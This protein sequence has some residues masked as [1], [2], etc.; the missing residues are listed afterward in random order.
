[1]R[2]KER[3]TLNPN[4]ALN[5]RMRIEITSVL[6][7]GIGPNGNPSMATRNSYRSYREGDGK[8]SV[9]GSL[10]A[11]LTEIKADFVIVLKTR[12]KVVYKVATSLHVNDM[13]WRDATVKIIENRD[14]AMKQVDSLGKLRADDSPHHAFYDI[15]LGENLS[16]NSTSK[17]LLDIAGNQE[18]IDSALKQVLAK[19]QQMNRPLD[20]GQESILKNVQYSDHSTDIIRGPPGSGKTTLISAI[21]EFLVRCSDDIGIF[22]CAPSNGNTQR[23]HDAVQFTMK[24]E[25]SVIPNTKVAHASQDKAPQRVYRSHLEEEALLHFHDTHGKED[26]RHDDEV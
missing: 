15:F 18:T 2:Y 16:Q 9:S 11:N 26:D 13:I 21:T 17:W 5:D 23:I 1:M 24:S 12:K 22:L 10:V 8:F 7:E 4:V 20:S 14:Q 19:F 6:P 25:P 3:K